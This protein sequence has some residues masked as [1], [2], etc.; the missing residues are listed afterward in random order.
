MLLVFTHTEYPKG[1]YEEDVALRDLPENYVPGSEKATVT[2]TGQVIGTLIECL[3]NGVGTSRS[4]ATPD[5]N[6]RL[7]WGTWP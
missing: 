4:L 6:H 1:F 2:V 3:C 5:A 7:L